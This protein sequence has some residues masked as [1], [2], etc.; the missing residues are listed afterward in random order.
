MG[1]KK[2]QVGLVF[3][4]LPGNWEAPANIFG[5]NKEIQDRLESKMAEPC[6]NRSKLC[7]YVLFVLIAV[8]VTKMESVKESVNTIPLSHVLHYTFT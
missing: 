2:L 5:R 1:K 8:D 4:I 3:G 7:F 6:V